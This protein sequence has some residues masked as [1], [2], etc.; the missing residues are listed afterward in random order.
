MK[1]ALF[2]DLP[3]FYSQIA[4]Y[5]LA[6]PLEWR[7]YFTEWFDF[8]RLARRITSESRDVWVFH[9]NKIGSKEAQITDSYLTDL[10]KRFNSQNGVT[11]RNVNIKGT[12]REIADRVCPNCASTTAVEFKSEK[13]ID[14]S[15]VVHLFDTVDSWDVA[16]ILSGDADFVPAVAALRRRGKVVNGLGVPSKAS[17]ALIRECFQY[18]DL[19]QFL[20]D[21]LRAYRFCRKDGIV[22]NFLHEID[23]L[24]TA[25][26]KN[27]W[28]KL[29]RLEP[30]V[31]D[32]VEYR[33]MSSDNRNLKKWSEYS[34]T[35]FFGSS[36][37]MKDRSS[38]YSFAHRFKFDGFFGPI[39][40]ES[41]EQLLMNTPFN[42]YESHLTLYNVVCYE[43]EMVHLWNS[44][45]KTFR[46][47]SPTELAE[48]GE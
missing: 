1:H 41:L 26:E 40:I 29:Q 8:D 47:V 25:M 44:A 18:G 4:T 35:Q 20:L 9:S 32:S 14:T 24:P 27:V 39:V 30:Q 48:L 38:S 22:W 12:Q 23:V 11:A 7:K 15:L 5:Y 21:D 10:V 42:G 2:V 45:D 37:H 31:R 28:V 34:S 6:E 13:G 19:E 36:V 16:H 46:I 3:N 17:G 33:L 43:T